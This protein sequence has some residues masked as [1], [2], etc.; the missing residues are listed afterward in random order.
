MMMSMGSRRFVVV[1]ALGLIGAGCEPSE[2]DY[3]AQA[4][5]DF[6]AANFC[7]NHECSKRDDTYCAPRKGARIVKS[8]VLTTQ[9]P[10]GKLREV[11]LDF[12]GPRGKGQCNYYY[13]NAGPR[14]ET[15]INVTPK[16][17][18]PAP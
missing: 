5:Q 17:S 7:C 8:T 3:I 16:C 13:W 12:E 4:R 15:N 18:L 14:I 11:V 1:L 6:D 10:P 9:G 2:G